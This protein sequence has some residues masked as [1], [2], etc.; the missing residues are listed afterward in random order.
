MDNYVIF[1]SLILSILLIIGIINYSIVNYII[2][3]KNDDIKSLLEV[4][5]NIILI[6]IL[7]FGLKYIIERKNIATFILI[8]PFALKLVYMIF[9][10][11]EKKDIFPYTI[12]EFFFLLTS[13]SAISL[14]LYDKGFTRVDNRFLLFIIFTLI[15]FG[16]MIGMSFNFQ[17]YID[18]SDENVS[19]IWIG[20]AIG[21]FM[22]LIIL[23]Y[24]LKYSMDFKEISIIFF[25][26][27]SAYLLITTLSIYI[28]KLKSMSNKNKVTSIIFWP[29]TI[30]IGLLMG[31]IFWKRGI[32]IIYLFIYFA[33]MGIIYGIIYNIIN[34]ELPP[35]EKKIKLP[36]IKPIPGEI[37]LSA[38]KL[39]TV[40]KNLNHFKMKVSKK[41]DELFDKV[42]NGEIED[43]NGL[44]NILDKMTNEALENQNIYL[45]Y[46][47]LQCR[48]KLVTDKIG[49]S[50]KFGTFDWFIQTYFQN[51]FQKFLYAISL[52]IFVGFF[53][54]LFILNSK[55]FTDRKKLS[56]TIILSLINIGILIYSQNYWYDPAV[57]YYE[58]LPKDLKPYEEN[59]NK[60][61]IAGKSRTGVISIYYVLTFIIS[62]I[63][64]ILNRI[65]PNEILNIITFAN[66]LGIITAF[67]IY[68]G[69]LLPHLMIIL[70]FLQKFYLQYPI[71][72]NNITELMI[73]ITKIIFIVF[74]FGISLYETQY[75]DTTKYNIYN[76]QVWFIFAIIVSIFIYNLII[77]YTNAPINV[78]EYNMILMPIMNGVLQYIGTDILPGISF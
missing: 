41:Y 31:Y 38:E 24:S 66:L 30:F 56:L 36:D 13:I 53:I 61:D 50:Y 68:Y 8:I 2:Y 29:V 55:I 73:F 63:T 12:I 14:F 67:N 3:A 52:I 17:K 16:L 77:T 64:L 32:N 47:L 20:S 65:S 60:N 44:I 42:I 39:E 48:I 49:Y 46:Q 19:K 23:I 74:L 28:P 15:S 70:I 54:Y 75:K 34:E 4:F 57:K 5:G 9:S 18:S 71:S 7:I 45:L 72:F 26:L 43:Y 58:N 51:N 27:L 37:T 33:I 62:M 11:K 78:Y 76:Q 25:I 6:I 59:L 40:L 10:K 21:F 1:G 69:I 35:D 22:L